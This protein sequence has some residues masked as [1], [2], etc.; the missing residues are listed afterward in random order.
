MLE[1]T[2]KY[3]APHSEVFSGLKVTITG[4]EPKDKVL[5]VKKGRKTLSIK[6]YTNQLYLNGKLQQLSLPVVYVDKTDQFYLPT[7]LR[8]L[9]DK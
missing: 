3:F 4:E 7:S 8:A 1:L 2:D 9:L 6:S 5:T